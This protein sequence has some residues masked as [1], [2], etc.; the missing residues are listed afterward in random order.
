MNYWKSIDIIQFIF[1]L[2][3]R[4]QATNEI[5]YLDIEL[6]IGLLKELTLG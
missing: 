1:H 2:E 5:Q 4:K 6:D 3:E